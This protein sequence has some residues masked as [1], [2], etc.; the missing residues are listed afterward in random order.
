MALVCQKSKIM[1]RSI[2]LMSGLLALSVSAQAISY[3]FAPKE[4]GGD[5]LYDLDHNHA[6]AWGIDWQVPSGQEITGATLKIK[7]I[8]D[9]RVERDDLWIHLL[10]SAKTTKEKWTF[11]NWQFVKITVAD[12]VK[13]YN[14]WEG[15]GDYFENDYDGEET[16][17]TH[18]S[19]PN[20]GSPSD[21][22]LVYHF[23]ASQLATLEDYLADGNFGL[24]FDAD[25]HYYNDGVKLTIHT[26]PRNVPEAASTGVLLLSGLAGL[27][28]LRRKTG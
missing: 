22:D 26:A 15:G 3:T 24:G 7:D 14:D 10:D 11:Q 12:D 9:W 2:L 5:D 16:F 1:R 28:G 17:L 6:Y 4:S 27:A 21:F 20:G 13:L 23:D 8:W 19:D 25:C 18:W